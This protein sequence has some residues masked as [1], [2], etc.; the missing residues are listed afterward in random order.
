MINSVPKILYGGEYYKVLSKSR[1]CCGIKFF[2][3]MG[4]YIQSFHLD[5]QTYM[6]AGCLFLSS[7]KLE[8]KQ[9]HRGITCCDKSW[10]GYI[11][12][13]EASLELQE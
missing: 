13:W 10:R 2:V 6:Q 3:K 12:A 5:G 9:S 4:D 7:I 1:C 8:K 11:K